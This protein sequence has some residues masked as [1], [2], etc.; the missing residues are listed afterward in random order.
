[1]LC[2]VDGTIRE[3]LISTL[4]LFGAPCCLFYLLRVE[5]P[6]LADLVSSLML[7]CLCLFRERL[8]IFWCSSLFKIDD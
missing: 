5:V 7:T 2:F 4:L 3:L 6:P 8:M 1:M